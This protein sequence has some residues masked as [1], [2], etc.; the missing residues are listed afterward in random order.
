MPVNSK[1][2]A[3]LFTYTR[4]SGATRV[5]AAGLIV[6][7]DFSS[8][9]H[10]VTT[11]SKSFTLAADVNVNRDWEVGSAVRA[12]GQVGG[13]VLLGTVT[14]YAPSTQALVINVTSV[15]GSG[16]GLTN[17]RIGSLE[18]RRDFDPVTLA[19][20][21]GLVEGGATNRYSFS[22]DISN[23]AWT[24]EGATAINPVVSPDGSANAFTLV[25]D[26]TTG[27]H[28]FRRVGLGA[29]AGE[30][31]QLRFFVQPAGRSRLRL[32]TNFW[33]A[34]SENIDFNFTNDTFTA[35]ARFTVRIESFGAFKKVFVSSVCDVS[36]DRANGN[37][38]ILGNDAGLFSYTGDGVSGMRFYGINIRSGSV[39]T[40]DIPTTTTQ[41]TR[42]AD[43]L[44]I[45]GT[46]FSQFYNSAQGTLV[47]ELTPIAS[48]VGAVAASLNDG[49]LNNAIRI[50]QK[51][52][53]TQSSI[54][55]M[56]TD[57]V[58]DV[59][60][61]NAAT[62]NTVRSNGVDY[63]ETPDQSGVVKLGAASS[64]VGQFLTVGGTENFRSSADSGLTY[65]ART[66]GGTF[67][68]AH[69]GL[70]RFVIAGSTSV[71]NGA[72]VGSVI[73][74]TDGLAFRRVNIPGLA[75][76]LN[77]VTSNGTNQY[78]AVGA[79]GV[80]YTSPDAETWTAQTS[81]TTAAGLGIT[82]GLGLY[83][84][85]HSSGGGR[86]IGTSPDG[87]TWTTRLNV[88]QVFND[89]AFNGTNLFVTVASAGNIYTSS[90][91]IT[92]TARTS[93]VAQNLNGIHFAD[94]LWVA[95][96]NTGTV[97]TSP[98][99]ITWTDRT[100]NSG[101][102]QAI[103]EVNF[104][105]GKFYYGAVSPVLASNTASNIVANVTWTTLNSSST[106]TNIN[107]LA[108]NGSRL[109][110][111]GI[112]GFIA[113]SDDGTTFAPRTGNGTQINGAAFGAGTYVIVGNAANG[114][115]LIATV[116]PTTFE[117]QR[118][119]SNATVNMLSVKFTNG[120]FVALG[121]SSANN[122][123]AILT[124]PDGVTW[125]NQGNAFNTGFQATSDV[126]WSGSVYA[127][128][129]LNSTIRI[130]EN[131]GAAPATVFT[132]AGPLRGIDY[133]LGL[134]VA[135][136]NGGLIYTSPNGTTWTLRT[137]G[138]TSTLHSVMYS[139]RD[140]QWYAAGDGG[141]ILRSADAITWTSIANDA[142]GAVINSGVV[143]SNPTLADL[144]VGAVNKVAMRLKPNN[145]GV[146]VNG[147]DAVVDVSGSLP[148]PNRFT[149]GATGTGTSFFN[150]WIRKATYFPIEKTDAELKELST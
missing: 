134:F 83:V 127:I 78:V 21:G 36:G 100:A 53:G 147:A 37:L 25:E 138:V 137:S 62:G 91:G 125:T 93:G 54:R 148:S 116:N 52:S 4:D 101:T 61:V 97:V 102:T 133:A 23:A 26:I 12:V 29:V 11:G 126:A 2:F 30:V 84:A 90:D 38:F 33:S 16:T 5:N 60:A 121:E 68:G 65:N 136:G 123:P 77:E 88:G 41:V 76:Q 141:V 15:T 85:S 99:G 107:G 14:S 42:A 27:G 73:V 89:V 56:A 66:I 34:A 103:Q 149:I 59:M 70:G 129:T 18:F 44:S 9:S 39:D 150:G 145:F 119:V 111:C 13:Q 87:I 118:R 104:F 92:W 143:Q 128:T 120:Q 40:S 50:Q 124:S 82:F 8:T 48:A 81:G 7:V 94:G 31:H 139:T 35:N 20:R 1:T 80:I 49:T 113:S 75:Q 67:A 122:S 46:N 95:V 69:F 140:Q 96:G 105:N 24:K 57:G 51:Q 79:G 146:S 144:N 28:Q 3:E 114:S 108:T 74:S 130:G 58:T 112:N 109:L 72:T 6:G 17:W 32:Q 45:G 71:I 43:Q 131:L 142:I 10:D 135:V 22:N 106:N 117:Y 64:G 19:P 63:T 86:S 47:M 110:I 55:K 115:G 98:D 132:A